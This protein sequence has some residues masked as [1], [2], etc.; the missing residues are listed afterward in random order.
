M[1]GDHLR[2]RGGGRGH[3]LPTNDRQRRRVRAGRAQRGPVDVGFRIR[4][5]LLFRRYLRG[6][7][8]A[9]RLEVRHRRHV[10]RHRQRHPGQL[11]CLVGARSAHARGDAPPGVRPRCPS[12]SARV[13][14]RR[15]CASRPRPSSSCS[16]SRTRPASTTACRGCSAWRSGC[17]T[18]CVSSAWRLSPASTWCWAAT[19]PPS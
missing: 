16:S 12:S 3:L 6:L 1:H 9:V 8:W 2:R 14:G 18:R 7:R 13:T 19:W 17:P 4:H 11:A 10:D 5:Q 15:V